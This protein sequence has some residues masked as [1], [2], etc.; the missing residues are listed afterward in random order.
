MVVL[1]ESI[2]LA[3]YDL[4]KSKFN[5]RIVMTG[6]AVTLLWFVLG[7]LS[8]SWIYGASSSIMS[9]MPFKMLKS[10]GAYIFISII[11]LLGI[12]VTFSLLMM[13]F[14]ELFARNIKK[15]SHTQFLPLVVTGIALTWGL[16]IYF[17]FNRLYGAFEH[18]LRSLPFNDT[19]QSVAAVMSVY[20]LY[21]GMIVTMAALTSFQSKYTLEKLRVEQYP[22]EKLLGSAGDTFKSTFKN[23]LIFSGI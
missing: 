3:M 4:L 15:K 21:S 17:G 8:W 23:I 22:S 20:L 5:A 16:I 14:G 6:V 10:D 7:W 1:I 11:W 13:F 19:D 2:S 12:L 9:L 18:I